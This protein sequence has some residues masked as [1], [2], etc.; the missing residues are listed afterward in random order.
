MLNMPTNIVLTFGSSNT[1][2]LD[3]RDNASGE[4]INNGSAELTIVGADGNS[5]PGH[6]WPELFQYVPGTDGK[7]RVVVEP[8]GIPSPGTY[9]EALVVFTVPSGDVK[10][11]WVPVDVLRCDGIGVGS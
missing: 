8:S 3:A 2:E 4:P 7:Y 5:L 1:V 10:R 9:C 11:C 6:T